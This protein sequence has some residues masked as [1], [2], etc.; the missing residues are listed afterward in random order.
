MYTIADRVSARIARRVGID[1]EQRAEPDVE[2]GFL[3]RFAA[4]RVFDGFADVDV[5]AR[6]GVARPAD[7]RRRISTMGLPG[8]VL[9]LDDDVDGD[10][11]RSAA[12]SA[13]PHHPRRRSARRRS[14]VSAPR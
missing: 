14:A 6:Q 5:A 8:P 13:D 10:L 9:E 1:A 12:A 7:D 2:A 4:R 3:A 11:G